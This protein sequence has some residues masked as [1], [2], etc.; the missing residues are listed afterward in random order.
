M[1]PIPIKHREIISS[2]PYFRVCA[3][4]NMDCN[5]RITIEHSFIYAGRQISEMWN[6]VPLCWAHH[7]GDKFV[8]E[9]NQMISLN[10]ATDEELSKYP[11]KNW[12]QLKKYLN[13]KWGIKKVAR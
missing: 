8:K 12:S 2:D 3:R 1:R 9:V 11:R 6:Y 13:E 4:L 7:L 5:G 10:R